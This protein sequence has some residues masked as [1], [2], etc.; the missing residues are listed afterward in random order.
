MFD[1]PG[2][3][4]RQHD[5]QL[6]TAP[7]NWGAY[8][9]HKSCKHWLTQFHSSDADADDDDDD[10]DDVPNLTHSGESTEASTQRRAW[11]TLSQ[12]MERRAFKV[13]EHPT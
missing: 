1:R 8:P 3:K 12:Q 6:G 13:P 7:E 11:L 4:L 2:S 5:V 10:D 9:L